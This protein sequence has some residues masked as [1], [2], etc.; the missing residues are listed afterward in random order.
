M[1]LGVSLFGNPGAG[2]RVGTV[3][4]RGPQNIRTYW[5]SGLCPSPQFVLWAPTGLP[6]VL[7]LRASGGAQQAPAPGHFC[8]LGQGSAGGRSLLWSSPWGSPSDLPLLLLPVG[9]PG[10]HSPGTL[11]HAIF[12]AAVAS[13]RAGM[14]RLQRNTHRPLGARC[15]QS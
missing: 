1:V 6:L 5:W 15:T 9:L 4:P 8:P 3:G 14:Y 2:T 10:S 13:L 11:A 12:T 7:A